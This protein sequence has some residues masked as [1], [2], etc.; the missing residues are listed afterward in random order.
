MGCRRDNAAPQQ[1]ST[2][3]LEL[4]TVVQVGV[5]WSHTR[6]RLFRAGWR[7]GDQMN[8]HVGRITRRS[9]ARHAQPGNAAAA[10]GM[11]GAGRERPDPLLACECSPWPA[12][13]AAGMGLARNPRSPPVLRCSGCIGLPAARTDHDGAALRVSR[14]A[15]EGEQLGF[16]L[17]LQPLVHEGRAL[18]R[19]GIVLAFFAASWFVLS[20]GM[21]MSVFDVS[22]PSVADTYYRGFLDSANRTQI[23]AYVATGGVLALIVFALSVV[24]VPLIIDRHLRA[25]HAMRV[26]LEVVVSNLPAMIVWAALITAVTAVGFASLLFGMIVLIP[27][28]VTPPGT[29]IGSWCCSCIRVV[30]CDTDAGGTAMRTMRWLGAALAA[31]MVPLTTLAGNLIVNG[32]FEQPVQRPGAICC[33]PRVP[34]SGWRV[35]ARPATSR[36]ISG[37]YRGGATTF[38][39]QEGC[40]WLDLT[41]LSNTATGIEQTVAT[42]PGTTYDLTF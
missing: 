3:T 7:E 32:G 10:V 33:S 1:S 40:Q 14:R 21:L 37:A 41:G 20:E 12:H 24:T 19:F 23:V 35:L 31:S 25:G 26:S 17:S 22:I 4:P 5:L 15:T 28:L 42:T 6:P 27:V 29:P 11:A 9:F 34:T 18:L 39:A 13:G 2:G 36:P 38:P 8:T 30:P 16:D